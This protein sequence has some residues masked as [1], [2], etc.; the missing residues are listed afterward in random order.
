[1]KKKHPIRKL[2]LIIGIIFALIFTSV[3]V[4]IVDFTDNTPDYIT[5]VEDMSTSDFLSYKAEK[6]LKETGIDEDFE[7]LFDEHD[8]NNLLATIVKEIEIPM[9]NLH[10]IYLS[11]NEDDTI[12][13]QAPFFFLFYKSCAKVKAKLTYD[14]TTLV[15]RI[16]EI[17][18]NLLSSNFGIVNYILSDQVV[19]DIQKAINDEGV[20]LKMWKEDNDILVSMTNIDI[21]KTI[22][23]CSKGSAFGLL[24]AAIVAGSITAKNVKLIVNQDGLTGVI[25][26]KSLV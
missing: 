4:L 24:G 7:Y 22:V 10:S 23:N 13:I 6:S 20:E 26:S 9:V 21:C 12:D 19:S 11:I 8:L 25:I 18:V 5:E 1:M 15:L 2:F 17:K 14:E 3:G 16:T